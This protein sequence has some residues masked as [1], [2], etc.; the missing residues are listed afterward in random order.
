M[1]CFISIDTETANAKRESICSFGFAIFQDGQLLEQ[2]HYLIDPEQEFGE[3]QKRIHGITPEKVAGSPTFPEI[4]P[5]LR[6]LLSN[7][8]VISH[9]V[10]DVQSIA[11][12]LARYSIPQ[13]KYFHIDSCQ[14]S[15]AAWPQLKNHKL[16]T[17]AKHLEIPLQHHDALEDARVAGLVYL[18]A[19]KIVSPP[20]T[21]PTQNRRPA[22]RRK[23]YK[24]NNVLDID[25]EISE[26]IFL[27][28]LNNSTNG[29]AKEVY[30]PPVRKLYRSITEPIRDFVDMD[31]RWRAEDRGLIWCWENGR[32]LAEKEPDLAWRAKQGELM[33]LALQGGFSGD[34][35]NKNKTGT[36]LYL[37]NWQGLRG[38][39]LDIDTESKVTLVCSKWGTM[40]T[41]Q[42]RTDID[43]AT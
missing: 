32:L 24:H 29:N 35:D 42:K 12:T 31:H 10:F 20:T 16:H 34:L 3:L 33:P 40:V 17:L 37:A 27:Q 28:I 41:Y 13:I 25:I 11:S 4:E 21:I 30:N 6:Q 2:K 5:E 1:N 8:T 38:E 39:D 18:E 7:Q 23:T 9:S 19:I 14:V 36:L 26:D 43:K 15:Q 22:R